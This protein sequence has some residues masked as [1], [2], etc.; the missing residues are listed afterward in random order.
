V[1]V[2]DRLHD[3]M[4]EWLT[5]SNAFLV[6]RYLSKYNRFEVD[7]MQYGGTVVLINTVHVDTLRRVRQS[8][9]MR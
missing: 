3:W 8:A 7:T 9:T 6:N 2:T 5:L 1:R 4:G